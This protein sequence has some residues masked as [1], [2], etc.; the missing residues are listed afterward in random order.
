[1]TSVVSKLIL[2]LV[3]YLECGVECTSKY[4]VGVT[5][6]I[7][8]VIPRLCLSLGE[9][10]CTENGDTF[11]SAVYEYEGIPCYPPGVVSTCE[12]R[13]NVANE[14]WKGT[15][16][17][18]HP[19]ETACEDASM[20]EVLTARCDGRDGT[21]CWTGLPERRLCYP[22]DGE[23]PVDVPH[24]NTG[25]ECAMCDVFGFICDVTTELEPDQL[26][27]DGDHARCLPPSPVRLKDR[28]SHHLSV[29]SYNVYEIPYPV[30]QFGQR[31]RVCRIPNRL[32]EEHPEVDVIIFQEVFLGGCGYEF[33][34]SLRDLLAAN[35]FLYTT[36]TVG[37]PP[38]LYLRPY[39]G[40]IFIASKWQILSENST[41][42]SPVGPSDD[43]YLAKGVAYAKIEKSFQGRSKVYHIFGTHLQYT[44]LGEAHTMFDVMRVLQVQEMAQFIVEQNIPKSEPVIVGGDFNADT[45]NNMYHEHRDEIFEILGA[46]MPNIIGNWYTTYDSDLIPGIFVGAE[47]EWIDYV[48]TLKDHQQ[49]SSSNLRS[50]RLVT[51]DYDRILYCYP[52]TVY[53]DFIFPP[54][55]ESENCISA[56]DLS[57]HFPVIGTFIFPN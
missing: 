47:R 24:I 22:R 7:P 53:T 55:T 28:H 57:D 3:I 11:E 21:C 30:G 12:E 9:L 15:A 6:N 52:D 37:D 42:F 39:N 8:G 29:I 49:P 34:V 25:L 4:E 54:I 17:F 16:P 10:S 56:I 26:F 18:C 19:S 43:I 45:Y 20:D 1:M 14:V 48:L 23:D 41:V 51:H 2:I 33:G 50:F 27:L 40:G 38:E 35:G 5:E 36:A 32:F 31:E 13:L 46:R 44:P